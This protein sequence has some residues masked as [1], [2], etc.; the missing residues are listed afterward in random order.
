[1]Y[2]IDKSIIDIYDGDPPPWIYASNYNSRLLDL[3]NVKY[4]LT[5]EK[6]E[7][8]KFK[9]VYNEDIR[10]YENTKAFPRV[11]LVPEAIVIKE[12]KEILRY[13]SSDDFELAKYVI[14]EEEPGI[15]HRPKTIDYRHEKEEVTITKYEPNEVAIN[16]LLNSSKFLILSDAYYPGWRVYIDG[17]E[18]RI[19][20]A[21][22]IMRAIHLERGYH[23]VAFIYDPVSFKIGKYI[24]F[25]SLISVTSFL[26]IQLATRLKLKK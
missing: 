21:N 1:M 3:L 24:S 15:G 16:V 23:K 20:K 6:I 13:L 14:L 11:F 18:D 8:S 25:L 2:L 12:K 4:I 17:K 7:E 10:I 9:L 19:F 26:G 5:T 22:Y